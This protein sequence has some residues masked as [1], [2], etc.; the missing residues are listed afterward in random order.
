MLDHSATKKSCSGKI[1]QSFP[2][3]VLLDD[4][5]HHFIS[6]SFL[7]PQPCCRGGKGEVAFWVD[8]QAWTQV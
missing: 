4:V 5:K 2:E 1:R 6:Q 8:T 3:V 7:T